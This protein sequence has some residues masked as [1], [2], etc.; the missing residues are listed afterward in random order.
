MKDSLIRDL[1][2]LGVQDEISFDFN[3]FSGSYKRSDYK[4]LSIENE[5]QSLLKWNDCHK[6]KVTEVYGY[7]NKRIDGLSISLRLVLSN[8]AQI[9][10]VSECDT[11]FSQTKYQPT[12]TYIEDKVGWL[13]HVLPPCTYKG[14]KTG[15]SI[16]V[17][18]MKL[19]ANS[20]DSISNQIL[21]RK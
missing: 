11:F 15:T 17:I 18:T 1:D 10:H 6:I 20:F 8:G 21:E 2:T 12:V 3:I 5:Y 13:R 14:R 4:Y 19:T 16:C 9:N 7:F